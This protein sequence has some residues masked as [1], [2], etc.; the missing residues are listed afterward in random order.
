MLLKNLTILCF[1]LAFIPKLFAAE[2]ILTGIYHGTNLYVQNPKDATGHYCISEVYVNNK[3]INIPISTAF[4]ID[5]SFL[6][7]E[8]PVV[9]KIVHNDN[10]LPKIINPAAIKPRDEFQFS[11]AEVTPNKVNW[12]AKGE[13]KFGQYFLEHYRNNAWSVEKVLNCK[14]DAGNNLYNV[15]ITHSQGENK[16]RIK[17]LEITGQTYYSPELSFLVTSSEQIEFYPQ[18]V[19]TTITF[20]KPVKYELK[21]LSENIVLRGEGTT[22]DC[23]NLASGNY[24]LIFNNRAEK[25]VKK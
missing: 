24:W 9:I 4:D 6:K 23:S 12:V 10:C 22:I 11:F 13:K 21:D 8:E 16:Y 3:K 18:N 14:G 20:S 2:L 17:Y 25:I 7:R 5:L 19:T 1:I 15:E